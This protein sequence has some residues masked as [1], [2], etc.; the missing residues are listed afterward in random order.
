VAA[1]DKAGHDEVGEME[2]WFGKR[3]FAT[4]VKWCHL[5]S[6]FSVAVFCD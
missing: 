3:D 5:I 4:S 2:R 1:E 6:S